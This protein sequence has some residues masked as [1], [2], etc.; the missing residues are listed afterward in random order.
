[1]SVIRKGFRSYLNGSV[2]WTDKTNNGDQWKMAS[3]SLPTNYSSNYILILE[4][5]VSGSFSG[6]VAIDDLKI[7]TGQLCPSAE[8][9]C[10]FKCSNGACLSE[11]KV[12][13]F[14]ND[15]PSGEDENKCGYKNV[16]F[17]T[18]TDNWNDTSDLSTLRWVRK[19]NGNNG[20]GGPS[21][22]KI[23]EKLCYFHILFY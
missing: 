12:C 7:K 20:D 11:T 21:T 1:M 19:S 16:T 13:N 22:G 14:I 18:G 2:I 6:D 17:E 4:G 23:I 8:S 9:L 10:A 15:C 5:K 3:V